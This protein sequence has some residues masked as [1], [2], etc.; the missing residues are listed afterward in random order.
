M[1]DASHGDPSR[2]DG[3]HTK[4]EFARDEVLDVGIDVV[5]TNSANISAPVRMANGIA[6]VRLDPTRAPSSV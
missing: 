4:H 1:E 6:V 5:L 2:C 3:H